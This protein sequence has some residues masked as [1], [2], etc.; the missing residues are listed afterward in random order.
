MSSQ[1]Q[2][3]QAVGLRISEIQEKIH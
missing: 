2:L 3:E 1:A